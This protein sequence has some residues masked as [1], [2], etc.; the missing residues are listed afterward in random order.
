MV[1]PIDSVYVMVCMFGAYTPYCTGPYT[2][3]NRG[4][5]HDTTYIRYVLLPHYIPG[6]GG[7]SEGVC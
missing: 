2:L 3:A 7:V 1:L 5:A 6:M 4:R